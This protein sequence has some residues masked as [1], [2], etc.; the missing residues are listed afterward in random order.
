MT[1]TQRLI[2]NGGVDPAID[3]LL[4]SS[5]PSVRA[6]A[7]TDVLG[8]RPRSQAVQEAR[9]AIPRGPRVRALLAGQEP[10]GS[11]GNHPYS[12]WTGAHWR[13]VNLVELGIP[14]GHRRALAAANDVLRWLHRGEQAR[15]A[16]RINGLVRRHASQEGNAITVCVRLGRARDPLVRAL[17]DRLLE[18][19]WPDGGWNCDRAPE[20][21][22]S[23][24]YESITPM[25][26]LSEYAR[27]T[28]D[29]EARAAARRAAELFLERRLFR[30]R[31][32]GKVINTR[33][34]Q[35]HYPLY[36][37][38]DILHGLVLLSRVVGLS[39]SRVN[40]ALDLLESK[41]RRDG[42]WWAG[43]SYWKPPGRTVSGVD[44]ADWGRRGPNEMITLNALRV[45]KSAGRL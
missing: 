27:A 6:L 26:G 45:L 17:V 15:P 44:V 7:L 40:D 30:S 32:S 19:Q 9:R 31:R 14:S 22:T 12:K 3:W 42:T 20:A 36:W 4:A 41:R 21:R 24:F 23:S 38:Y 28:G 34:L 37:H 33:W 35:L 39:D 29:A 13:L 18:S 11:F 8:K 16:P 43:S 25:W 10:D 2:E 1:A 5:D